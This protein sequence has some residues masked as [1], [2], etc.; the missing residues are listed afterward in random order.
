MPFTKKKTLTKTRK[1]SSISSHNM[2]GGMT[3]AQR[4][5]F[6]EG[7]GNK[8]TPKKNSSSNN[9]R[10]RYRSRSRSKSRS[11]SRSRTSS[12]VNIPPSMPIQSV[13]SLP[14]QLP[15]AA[16]KKAPAQKIFFMSPKNYPIQRQQ[17]SLSNQKSNGFY[18]NCSNAPPN[19]NPKKFN[20]ET[21]E[22]LQ[23]K[24][25]PTFDYDKCTWFKNMAGNLKLEK[26]Y[27]KND[28]GKLVQAKQDPRDGRFWVDLHG[29]RIYNY[30]EIYKN[31]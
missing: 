22:C 4:I 9:S 25:N 31:Y 14:Y 23:P 26:Q 1:N 11:R 6:F 21:C 10:S 29:N 20:Y 15:A 17:V 16:A 5:A 8:M 19:V 12:S 30:A 2:R 7:K 13:Q 28:Q 3:F 18:E 24:N 27:I